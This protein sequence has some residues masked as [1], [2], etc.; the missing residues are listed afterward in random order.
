MIL[1]FVVELFVALLMHLGQIVCVPVSCFFFFGFLKIYI[2][3]SLSFDVMKWMCLALITYCIVIEYLYIKN[4]TIL[5]DFLCYL[6]G[7]LLTLLILFFLEI[8]GHAEMRKPLPWEIQEEK[9]ASLVST[10]DA[11]NGWAINYPKQRKVFFMAGRLWIFYSDGKDAVFRSSV[12]GINWNSPTVFGKGG[13]FGHRFGCWFDGVHFHYALCT[14]ALG[15]DVFYRRGVPAV[16]GTIDWA[17]EEQAAYD[18]TPDKNV[19]YPK[20][21]VD[22]GGHPWISFMQLVYQ[23]PN[24][25]PYD[26]LVLKSSAN[27]GTWKT[28]DGFPFPL[29]AQKMVAGYPDP[30][31]VP[32]TSGKTLWFYNTHLE[33]DDIYASRI[34]DGHTWEAEE[35]VVNPGS[36]YSFFNAV[37][38]GDDVHVVHGAGTI[39]YQKRTW[40]TGWGNKEMIADN[41]S[42]H[43]SITRVSRDA[44]LITWLDMNNNTVCCREKRRDAW[45]PPV[46]WVDASSEGLAGAGINLNTLVESSEPFRNA[47]VYTTGET[48]PFNIRCTAIAMPSPGKP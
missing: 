39:Y 36:P 2:Y 14:A 38:D 33:G 44:V 25:P 40:G 24:T 5:I 45:L 27:D 6:L 19:M 41:A 30:V 37:A 31:G 4:K 21:I 42:G 23:E 3:S 13:H 7:A 8:H 20:I 12:D 29:V 32:L 16:D 28:E 11:G 17:T 10:T 22:S 46:V 26:T 48:A 35:V 15:A 43:T 1:Y 9:T 18:T 34:W 47:A